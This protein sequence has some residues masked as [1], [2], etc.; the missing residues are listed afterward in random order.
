[1]TKSPRSESAS[2]NH[3]GCWNS[4]LAVCAS[5]TTSPR[6][7]PTP[8]TP[9]PFSL[10]HVPQCRGCSRASGQQETSSVEAQVVRE[11]R[12]RRRG[13]RD[14]FAACRDDGKREREKCFQR[15]SGTRPGHAADSTAVSVVKS[16]RN[17]QTCAVIR[18]SMAGV[19]RRIQTLPS[20]AGKQ[21]DRVVRGILSASSMSRRLALVAVV[22]LSASLVAAPQQGTALAG[23]NES[24]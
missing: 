6:P 1:M 21:S 5:Q 18:A 24:R 23:R 16:L 20:V 14:D 12:T 2:S 13:H 9:R 4:S 22:T 3:V 15:G 17:V 8:S 7:P 19:T 11:H 10:K